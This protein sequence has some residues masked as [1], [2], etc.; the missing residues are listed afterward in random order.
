MKTNSASLRPNFAVASRN[1][2]VM[3]RVEE[4]M[5]S[6]TV[7]IIVKVI[8]GKAK[9]ERS[10]SRFQSAS[11]KRATRNGGIEMRTSATGNGG[12][13]PVRGSP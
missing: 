1:T 2:A 10:Q 13:V 9:T 6:T 3:S 8:Y 5:T 4:N 7:R 12:I 11:Q